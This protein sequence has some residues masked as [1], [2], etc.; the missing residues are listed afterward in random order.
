MNT[1]D[2]TKITN[3]VKWLIYIN[4]AMITIS[5]VSSF[6]QYNLA[7]NFENGI[8]TDEHILSLADANDQRESIIGIIAFLTYIMCIIFVARWIFVSS[9]HNHQTTAE[10]LKYTPGW[11]VGWYFVPVLSFWEPYKAFKQIYQVSVDPDNW[12]TVVVPSI[13]QALWGL[14]LITKII[15]YI[16]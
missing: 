9:K 7:V 6:M 15:G 16:C 1:I 8:Y 14:W 10:D 5:A 11:S 3:Y 12:K 4:M 13:M 2:T